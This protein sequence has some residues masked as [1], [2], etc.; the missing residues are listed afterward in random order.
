MMM[1]VAG[2]ACPIIGFTDDDRFTA[3][4]VNIEGLPFSLWETAEHATAVCGTQ[5]KLWTVDNEGEMPGEWRYLRTRGTPVSRCSECRA[6]KKSPTGD[7]PTA[8]QNTPNHA[9]NCDGW[10]H[11]LT[12]HCGDCGCF[13]CSGER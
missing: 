12:G 4:R 13:T 8:G 3:H 9:R 7:R 6:W 2:L 10:H 1:V 5:V 11:P